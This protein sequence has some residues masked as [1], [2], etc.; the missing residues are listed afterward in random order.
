[1]I[2]ERLLVVLN[3]AAWCVLVVYIF[4]GALSLWGSVSYANDGTGRFRDNLAGVRRTFPWQRRFAYA[5]LAGAYL[6]VM[7]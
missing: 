3:I 5:L 7:R 2:T 4:L 1:M 6:W